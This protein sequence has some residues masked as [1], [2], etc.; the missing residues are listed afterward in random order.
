MDV[1]VNV[2]GVEATVTVAGPDEAVA[3]LSSIA[4]LKQ[5]ASQP[6]AAAPAPAAATPERPLVVNGMMNLPVTGPVVDE[7]RVRA[8]LNRARANF[9]SAKLLYTLATAGGMSDGKLRSLMGFEDGEHFGPMLSHISKCCKREE[10]PLEAIVHKQTRRGTRGKMH[11]YFM[12]TD[13]AS[14]IIRSIDHFEEQPDFSDFDD[15]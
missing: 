14:S 12:V 1:K 11:Y 4:N 2:N 10:I 3:L 7:D 8:A 9:K 5:T 15:Q 6:P 13:Q